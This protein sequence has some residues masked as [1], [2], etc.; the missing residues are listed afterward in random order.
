MSS[1]PADR[2]PSSWLSTRIAGVIWRITPGCREAARLTSEEREH[3]LPF[4]T[5][6]RLGLHRLFCQHCARYAA[7]L[8]LIHDAAQGLPGHWDETKSPKL[9]GDAKSRLKRALRKQISE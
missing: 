9:A 4:T 1:A 3:E 7:Q 2:K 6:T 5:R 8:D